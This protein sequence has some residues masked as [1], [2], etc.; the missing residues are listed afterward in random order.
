LTEDKASVASDILET[1][2]DRKN[3]KNAEM[4]NIRVE[5]K[6]FKRR[7]RPLE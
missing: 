3:R 1:N 7:R 5:G 4:I 2:R 6:W